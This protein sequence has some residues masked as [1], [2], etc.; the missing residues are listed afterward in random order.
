MHGGYW[1]GNQEEMDH[2]VDIIKNDLADH[3]IDLAYDR[4][5]WRAL[6]INVTKLRFPKNDGNF[7]SSCTTGSL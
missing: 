7:L 2:W 5:K 3:W 6:V 1:W 4:N